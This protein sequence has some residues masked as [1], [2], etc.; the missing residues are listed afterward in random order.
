MTERA[1]KLVTARNCEA[2][3][4]QI[5]DQDCSKT[6]ELQMKHILHDFQ[7]PS[8]SLLEKSQTVQTVE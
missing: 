2:C 1:N 4:H 5:E 6:I 3:E 8:S 7:A